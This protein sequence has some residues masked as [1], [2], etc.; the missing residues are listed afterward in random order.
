MTV[1]LARE[2][3]HQFDDRMYAHCLQHQQSQQQHGQHRQP[4]TAA[5]QYMAGPPTSSR[6]TTSDYVMYTGRGNTTGIAARSPTS[7]CHHQHG[8]SY[9][10]DAVP[11][12]QPHQH[13]PSSLQQQQQHTYYTD[14][15]RYQLASKCIRPGEDGQ[16]GPL[17]TCWAYPSVIGDADAGEDSLPGWS[18][19]MGRAYGGYM[20]GDD[21]LDVLQH[22]LLNPDRTPVSDNVYIYQVPS[23]DIS[24]TAA[25]AT[26]TTPTS[27]YRL[28]PEPDAAVVK[29]HLIDTEARAHHVHSG[30]YVCRTQSD[31][32]FDWM[33][34]QAFSP[35]TPTGM[36]ARCFC[37]GVLVT[38]RS[39]TT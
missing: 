30:E 25:V 13:P 37:N 14:Y 17:T 23:C 5:H 21:S 38:H 16:T 3:V 6:S 22:Q 2:M 9:I 8:V 27:K 31:P 39:T 24:A 20:A 26:A 29:Q 19:T 7:V 32:A 34:K 33:K 18:P 28:H 36:H 11:T 1:H 12:S 4:L 10:S 35:V 15:Q